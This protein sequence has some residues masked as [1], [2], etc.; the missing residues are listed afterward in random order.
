M[1]VIPF[2]KNQ[3]KN[4]SA[5]NQS[6]GIHRRIEPYV[7]IHIETPR[8]ILKTVDQVSE[9]QEV[10]K[11][12]LDLFANEYGIDTAS[13]AMDIDQFDFSCDHLIIIEKGAHHTREVVGTYR[14]LCSQFTDK[15]YSQTEFHIDSFLK[16]SEI[17]LELGRACIRPDHRRGSALNLLWRGIMQ[18]A[19]KTQARYLFGLSSVKSENFSDAKSL[20]LNLLTQNKI[21]TEWLI[22]PV[23]KYAIPEFSKIEPK[24]LATDLPSLFKSYLKAGAKV[25]S[26]PAYDADFHCF[27]FLTILDLNFL[28]DS[29]ER[30][31]QES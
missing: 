16:T 9:F 11:L 31:Y 15:F 24:E 26:E 29:Y 3:P 5:K 7:A 6:V 14:M 27:D 1:S 4:Q 12:R 23:Q 17:K 22:T 8:Y 21:S 2:I 28:K 18:Y 20:H 25:Y 19:N 10:L 30:K 13:I